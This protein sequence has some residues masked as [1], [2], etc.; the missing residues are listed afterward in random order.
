[1]LLELLEVEL[2]LLREGCVNIAQEVK[3]QE[4]AAVVGAQ[5]NL[6]TWVCRYCAEALVSVAVG[7]TLADDGIPEEYAGLCRLPSV[8]DNLCPE[9]LRVDVLSVDGAIAID[10][11]LLTV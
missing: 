4:T 6:A 10:G 11:E 3:R 8:V 7:H 2:C 1:M 5:W 9:L